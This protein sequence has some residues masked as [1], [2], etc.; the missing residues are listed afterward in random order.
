MK[1]ILRDRWKIEFLEGDTEDLH[2]SLEEHCEGIVTYEGVVDY[3]FKENT[4]LDVPRGGKEIASYVLNHKPDATDRLI[5]RYM[6]NFNK[7]LATIIYG[8]YSAHNSRV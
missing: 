8:E 3:L 7:I 5:Y 6:R 2:K 4:L 1:K